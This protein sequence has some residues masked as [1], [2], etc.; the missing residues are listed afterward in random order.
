VYGTLRPDDDSGAA[1]TKSF[2]EGMD[3]EVAFLAGASLYIDGSYPAVSLEETHCSVR[4]AFLQ[5]R[6]SAMLP[7]KLSE[8]DRIEGF[9]DLY[10]RVVR[11][12]RTANGVTRQAYVYH[13][14]GRTDRATCTRVPDGD[15]LSRK[16]G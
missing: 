6:S 13:R 9:P 10:E 12:V 5:P 16:R 8:A 3:S 2:V 7:S 1:W 14:T 4:G 15:W 11:P